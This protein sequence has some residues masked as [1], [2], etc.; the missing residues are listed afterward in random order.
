MP[1]SARAPNSPAPCDPRSTTIN[2]AYGS[3]TG[4]FDLFDTLRITTIAGSIN[5]TLVLQPPHPAAPH[6]VPE[7]A[8][9]SSTG[10]ITVTTLHRSIPERPYTTAIKTRSGNI[11]TTLP[12]SKRTSI[13]TV[14]GNIT[15]RLIPIGPTSAPSEIDIR[16]ATG[17]TQVT[18]HA[19]LTQPTTPL[20]RISADY[21]GTT[22]SLNIVYP[23]TWQGDITSKMSKGSVKHQWPG[24]RVMRF[25]PR[26]TAEKGS[27]LGELTIY[28]KGMEVNL[29][30]MQVPLPW[31]EEAAQEG[32]SAFGAGGQWETRPPSYVGFPPSYQECVGMEGGGGSDGVEGEDGG[33]DDMLRVRH[34]LTS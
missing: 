13:H 9:S 14:S 5:I 25:G 30:G 16:N 11:T 24:L 27:A 10:S 6:T 32:A 3:I 22:G 4:T 2:K 15:A 7:L 29:M 18:L 31:E 20:R 17:S 28:G 21:H 12:H 34:A 19:H 23:L 8:L 1:T 33:M 26:F